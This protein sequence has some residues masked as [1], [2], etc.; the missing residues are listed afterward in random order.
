MLVRSGTTG[1]VR[2]VDG[3]VVIFRV[4]FEGRLCSPTWAHRGPAVAYLS[5]LREGTR[6]PEF[7]VPEVAL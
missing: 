7:S 4:M 6:K 5:A 3:D 1:V 2:T